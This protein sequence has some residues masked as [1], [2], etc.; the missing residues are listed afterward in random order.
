MQLQCAERVQSL[1]TCKDDGGGG[2]HIDPVKKKHD[3]SSL[4]D[5][6]STGRHLLMIFF[7][8]NPKVKFNT[9]LTIQSA[10]EKNCI[11]LHSQNMTVL[12]PNACLT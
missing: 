9:A 5:L 7:Y 6:L 11:I 3:S 2:T 1:T 12:Q 4:H 8:K 10:T